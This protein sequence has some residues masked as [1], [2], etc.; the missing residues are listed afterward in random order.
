VIFMMTLSHLA[1]SG[2]MT[3]LILGTADPVVLTIG[4][5]AGLLPDVDISKS[6]AGR[7]L[8]PIS[9]YLEKRLPHRSCTHSVLASV[10]VAIGVY[11]LAYLGVIPRSI[12]HA[13]EIG[14]TFGYLVD[15]TTK[16]GIQ[17][18]FPATLRCVVPGNRKLRLSTGS[19][20]EYAI[21]AVVLALGMMVMSI[22]TRGGLAST[23][24]EILA[25][26]RGIQ[27]ILSK[28]GSTNQV[29]VHVEG[30]RLIDRVRV[31]KSFGVLEQRD[32]NTFVV[33]DLQQPQEL[34]QVGSRLEPD[35]QILSERITGQVGRAGGMKIE[36]VSWADEE[37]V[38][39]LGALRDRYAGAQI[40]LTGSIEVE[41]GE[42]V[43]YVG[44]PYELVTLV[45]RGNRVELNSCPLGE[46][47]G[48][49][50]EQW[51]TGQV[52]VRIIN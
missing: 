41:E 21:L 49:L 48:V 50:G 11:S 17:L 16:S 22:N 23:F 2:L 15:L 35:N 24:N 36:T 33:Y 28:H 7:L 51:G 27:E 8:P 3:G 42:E 31:S 32:A 37:I 19:N 20:W 52:R 46:A 34:Y 44:R 6:P 26:P 9:W 43:R 40:Y 47:I 38:G 13:V 45:R 5:C 18:F 10:L 14:Y 1:I 30:V 29:V 25:T 39:K 12:A 4:A